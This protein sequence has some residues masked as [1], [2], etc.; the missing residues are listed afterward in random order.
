MNQRERFIKYLEGKAV[1]RIPFMEII[2]WGQTEDRWFSEGLPKDANPGQMFVGGNEY[3]GLDGIDVIDLDLLPPYPRRA[4]QVIEEDDRYV[5]F[6]DEF[7]RKRKALKEGTAHD[8][9]MSMDTYM[10]WPIKSYQDFEEYKKG[11]SADTVDMRYPKNWEEVARKANEAKVPVSLLDP[12]VGTFGFYSMLRN[13]MGTEGLSYMLYDDPKLINDCLDMLLEYALIA[14]KRVLEDANL[15][16]YILHEDMCYKAGPLV[17]PEQFQ[18]FFMPRYRVFIDFLKSGGV[19][20][21]MIDTDGNFLKLLPFYID[22][23][24][25]SISPCECAAG[26]DVVALRKEYPTLGLM[27]GIDKRAVAKGGEALEAEVKYKIGS[28]IEKGRYIPMIDHSI[29]PDVSLK[30]FERYLEL[31]RKYM[32][33]G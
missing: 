30:N 24:I 4:E 14:F 13:F 8:T 16:Y 22:A 12:M 21:I 29:P 1:D 20:H 9:R 15:D 10:D 2:P 31:K 19:K 7:G 5:L 27:G 3:F 33:V 25:D 11:Y 28:I 6:I 18:E 17:S 26:M 23:G 32:E